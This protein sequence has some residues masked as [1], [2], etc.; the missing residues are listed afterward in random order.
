M[1]L[2]TVARLDFKLTTAAGDV[3]LRDVECIV[4]P[5][6]KEKGHNLAIL[7]GGPEMRRLGLQDPQKQL[8]A[9]LNARQDG[10]VSHDGVDAVENLELEVASPSAIKQEGVSERVKTVEFVKT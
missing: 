6:A 9:I 8:E 2:R 7:V 10:D 5:V 4:I 3:H 1:V